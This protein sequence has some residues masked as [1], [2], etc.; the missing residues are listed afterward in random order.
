[1]RQSE[2]PSAVGG[3]SLLVIFV[4]LCLT[5]FSVLSLSS[6]QAD[7]RL[8]AASADAV[9]GYYAA[10]SEAEEILAK[11]RR[12]EVPE[13]VQREGNRYM[14]TCA[15]SDVQTLRVEVELAGDSYRI[16][17]WQTEAVTEWEAEDT[18]HVWDGTS[19]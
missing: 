7:G 9:Y 11:L 17:Q 5:I 14:Y 6:V 8:S 13:G 1:M 3:S 4:V 19:E 10:D 18:L 2:T 16:I 15:V 12:G